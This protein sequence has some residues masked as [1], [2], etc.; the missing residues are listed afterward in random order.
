[1]LVLKSV[2]H[3]SRR[4]TLA[5]LLAT[6][7][8]AA[9]PAAA[10]PVSDLGLVSKGLVAVG[11]LPA[12]LRD[13][14]GE[15]FGSG[16]GL[17]ADPKSWER[18]PDG[19]HG[20]LYLLPD[21]GYNVSG[22]SDYRARL[23]KLTILLKPPADA[24]ALPTDARQHTLEMTLADSI[25]LTDAAGKPLTGLDPLVDGVRPAAGGFPP[26]PQADTGAVSIDAEAIVRLDDGSF[27]VSDEY[28]PYIYRFSA[29]GRM[30]SAIRPPEAFVPKRNGKDSFSS[31]NP[32]P[33]APVPKPANPETGRQ[34]NQG[35]EGMALTPD[36]KY[37]VVLL[38]SATRQ[39]GGSAPETRQNT[40]ML[41]YDMAD[42]E[43]P[44]LVREHVV[45]L[46]FY[47]TTDGKRRVAA[48]SELLALDD[49]RFLV[50]CRDSGNG[51]GLEGV[52]SL[53]R[54]VELLDTSK[55]TDI[56]GMKYDGGVSLAPAG[57]LAD[58]I[59]PASLTTVIDINDN[60]Q[61]NKFGLHNGEPNDRNNLYEK[62]EG[63][64]LAPALDPA[65][66]RDFFLFVSNDNDF[67][68]QNG[69]Q[70]G[71]AYKDAS[72]ADVDT[73]ILVYRVTIP[74]LRK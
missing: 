50:I 33:G 31:N 63:M 44:K 8:T 19:Y 68:T 65:N 71:A 36:G 38:Q 28:G 66:P 60:A 9:Q 70:V 24:A 21:R 15:T 10:D 57:K 43:H 16:S 64:A 13:K 55:A 59:V 37:L 67:I 14:F 61:L 54:A 1:M 69:F 2:R 73:M 5:M 41:Y 23:N 48:Q 45:P 74:E 6:A 47:T 20:T 51:Y 62:W 12:D 58:G 56:A 4:A 27:F 11:R 3:L 40:R 72:G 46:P 30:I 7:F 49:T 53:Y 29:D 42:R 18:G 34:N 52:T 26:M 25:L 22:T 17:A 35:F 39:D 32:G